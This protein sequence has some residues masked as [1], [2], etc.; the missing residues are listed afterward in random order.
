MVPF[1]LLHHHHEEEAHCEH[2]SAEVE[3]N[4]CHVRIYHATLSA[5]VCDHKAHVSDNLENCELCKFISTQ[6]Q[7]YTANKQ[8]IVK[9]Q[10]AQRAQKALLLY[11]NNLL[12]WDCSESLN[13]RAPPT[14]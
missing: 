6:R 1:N 7:Q 14:C 4:P 12:V 11:K 2:N 10:L 3:S 8:L 9:A 13:G 5:D